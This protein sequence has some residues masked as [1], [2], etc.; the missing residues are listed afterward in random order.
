MHANPREALRQETLTR[1]STLPDDGWL[2]VSFVSNLSMSISNQSYVL[3]ISIVP[4]PFENFSI[5]PISMFIL[6]FTS[7]PG[8]IW[9]GPCIAG[10]LFGFSMV[11]IYI[12]ANSVSPI[13]LPCPL[14]NIPND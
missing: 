11:I 13:H 12:S 4:L 1:V 6:A 5:L 3:I 14:L 8:M 7:Y 2:H 10:I 9:V